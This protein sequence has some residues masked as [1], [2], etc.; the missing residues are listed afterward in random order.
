MKWDNFFSR[1]DLSLRQLKGFPGWPM[2]VN[3]PAQG[4]GGLIRSHVA[5]NANPVFLNLL[6]EGLTGNPSQIRVSL[7]R[8]LQHSLMAAL[9][10]LTLPAALFAIAVIGFAFMGGLGLLIGWVFSLP[11]EWLGLRG[12]ARGVLIY[13]AASII[14]MMTV[15]GVMLGRTRATE[16]YTRFWAP[17]Q[18]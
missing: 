14:F 8:R 16:L 2:P 1:L 6:A 9:E 12:F 15:V 3:H 5:Y 18:T 13:C 17:D 10:N 11:L 7:F 4:L